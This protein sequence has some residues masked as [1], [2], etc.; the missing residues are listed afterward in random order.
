VR[1]LV[2]DASAA[3]DLVLR[4]PAGRRREP[5]LR[6]PDAD[7]HSPAVCDVEVGAALRRRILRRT[8]SPAVGAAALRDHRDLPITRYPHRRLLLPAFELRDNFAFADAL[9]VV[10]AEALQAVLVTGDR[11]L[12]RAARRIGLEVAT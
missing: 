3:V 12:A 7:L 5:V 9:Y 1:T 4:L 11:R 8:I 10:L 6:D 2:V